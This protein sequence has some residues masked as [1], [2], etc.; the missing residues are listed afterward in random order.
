MFTVFTDIERSPL[1]SKGICGHW[2]GTAM[3]PA[4]NKTCAGRSSSDAPRRLTVVDLGPDWYVG[5]ISRETVTRPIWAHGRV[6]G[7]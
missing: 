7:G 3:T 6:G 2:I 4:V 5:Q 1:D